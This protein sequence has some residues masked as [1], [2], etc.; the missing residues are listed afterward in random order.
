MG[1]LFNGALLR[2]PARV[3]KIKISR[4]T[5][6]Y[7]GIERVFF[8]RASALSSLRLVSSDVIFDV[9]LTVTPEDEYRANFERE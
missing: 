2:A 1:T 5:F 6:G 9:G 7:F 4:E 3:D 8:S